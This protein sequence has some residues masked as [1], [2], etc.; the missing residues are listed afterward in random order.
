MI[1]SRQ[2]KS[3]A[4]LAAMALSVFSISASIAAPREFSFGDGC[5]RFDPDEVNITTFGQISN[6]N[7]RVQFF[8]V[9]L[10][11]YSNINEQ[12]DINVKFLP[13][14]PRIN[15]EQLPSQDRRTQY[16]DVRD[17]DYGL[18]ELV[19]GEN[20][21]CPVS[22][23]STF[24]IPQDISLDNLNTSISCASQE[25]VPNCRVRYKFEN[26]WRATAFVP[27]DRIDLWPNV[28]AAVKTYFDQN[29][30]DCTP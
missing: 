1:P 26:A 18:L 16:C 30:Q 27:R 24:Y 6:P 9:P 13:S 10:H 21:S 23:I 2:R 7:A 12:I 22:N 19:A 20:M 15:Y 25:Y 11:E 14:P 4:L 28:R 17:A 29:L 5:L 8:T 3:R